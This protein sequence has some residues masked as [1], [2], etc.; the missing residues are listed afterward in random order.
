MFRNPKAISSNNVKLRNKDVQERTRTG[1]NRRATFSGV[2]D[3]GV[4][5]NYRKMDELFDMLMTAGSHRLDEQRVEFF[6]AKGSNGVSH[7]ILP[8][9][10]SES[11]LESRDPP[12]PAV[13]ETVAVTTASPQPRLEV[14]ETPARSNTNSASHVRSRS[15]DGV[16]QWNCKE[17]DMD[18]SDLFR[19]VSTTNLQDSSSDSVVEPWVDDAVGASTPKPSTEGGLVGKETREVFGSYSPSTLRHHSHSTS[20]FY[21]STLGCFSESTLKKGVQSRA[22]TLNRT[23]P[24]RR[25]HSASA[26]LNYYVDAVEL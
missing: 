18:M 26:T 2:E 9:T 3:V 19:P 25:Q 7:H 21:S 11:S 5:K 14:R 6:P 20:L 13:P 12:Q 1:V 17:T 15:L 22:H 23:A 10:S 8:L 24:R 16:L 4:L